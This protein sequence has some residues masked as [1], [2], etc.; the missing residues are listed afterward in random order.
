V[1]LLSA[2]N[3]LSIAERT[4]EAIADAITGAF[5]R[6]RDECP[7]AEYSISTASGTPQMH[8]VWLLLASSGE[9]PAGGTA[10]THAIGS[11]ARC[12][13]AGSGGVGDRR[14]ASLFPHGPAER[15]TIRRSP[16]PVLIEG[17]TGSGKEL[18]ARSIHRLSGLPP[19][20]LRAVNCAALPPDLAESLLFGH[21]KGAFTGATADSKG[22]FEPADGGTR[23]LDEIG[24]LHLEVQAKLLRVREDGI[25]QPVGA[26]SGFRLFVNDVRTFLCLRLQGFRTPISAFPVRSDSLRQRSGL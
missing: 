23:F 4:R 17:E 19:D 18:A 3:T 10:S 7:E 24:E 8:A 16:L 1:Y 2:Q 15:R 5:A 11:G 9:I 12:R 14:K 21:V 13:R 6:I 26:S 22:A 20:R 25:V